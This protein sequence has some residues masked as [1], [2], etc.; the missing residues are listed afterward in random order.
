M[1]QAHLLRMAQK[2][3]E[4]N[5]KAERQAKARNEA[6]AVATGVS[7]TI[8]LGEQRGEAFDRPKP[9]RGGAT[10]PARRLNGLEW[11]MSGKKLTAEQ[12][13]AG[14]KYGAVYVR[15][16]KLGHLRSCL[17]DSVTGAG[18]NSPAQILAH[19][20]GTAAAEAALRRYRAI[21]GNQTQLIAVC[22]AICGEGM[23]PRETA[24]DGHQASTNIAVLRIA[25]DLLATS[26]AANED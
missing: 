24:R 8:G 2:E 23:T 1:T 11:L 12:Y 18:D 13:K 16:S 21:L 4:A 25:L 9:K 6:L 7:E 3:R 26:G 14:V 15:A 5:L 19:A 10:P 20:Y 17:D 22:D